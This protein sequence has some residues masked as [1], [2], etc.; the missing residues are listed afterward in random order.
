MTEKIYKDPEIGQVI[1]RRKAGV[2]RMSI[3]VHPVKG[4]TVSL[5][6]IF[7]YAV[8]EAFF[9]SKRDWVIATVTRQKEKYKDRRQADHAEIEAMRVRAKA[10]LPPRL[11]QL[12]DRYGFS[13]NRVTIKHNS[14]N[15]GSCSAKSNINLNLNIVRLPQV[16]RDYIMLHELCHLKHHDHGTAFHLLQEHVLT[17]NIMK[18]MDEGDALASEIARRAASSRARYPL[19][20]VLSKEMKAYMLY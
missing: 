18:L 13:F 1:F 9:M 3:R 4:V 6:Y 10:E 7:P 14:S 5:P 16:L 20:H 8:A 12:A 15:W 19:D 2:R 17:D 11:R